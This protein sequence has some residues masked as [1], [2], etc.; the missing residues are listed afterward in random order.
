MVHGAW[1]VKH[2]AWCMVHGAQA[3]GGQRERNRK[4]RAP[5]ER[6]VDC[7]QEGHHEVQSDQDLGHS[8]EGAQERRLEEAS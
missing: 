6:I 4:P 7:T 8:P 2:G 3:Q 1:C 5:N